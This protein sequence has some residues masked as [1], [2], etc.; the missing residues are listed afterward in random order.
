MEPG[1]RT[2]VF[3][4]GVELFDAGRY[5]AAHEIFEELW[6]ESEGADSDF[7]KGLVQA[8]IALR[9]FEEGN[10]EGAAKLYAGHRRC[11]ARYVPVHAGIDLARFL[12]EMEACLGPV[13]RR[14]SGDSPSFRG[15]HHPR[16]GPARAGETRAE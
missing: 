7:Y 15:A 14:R 13:F 16:L 2:A 3:R 4:A 9:H 5:L 6:E 1:E 11:L 12:A 8:A 10:L